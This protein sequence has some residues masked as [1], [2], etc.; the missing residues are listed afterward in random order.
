[1]L[2][3]QKVTSGPSHRRVSTLRARMTEEM[4]V[5]GFTVAHRACVFQ[6]MIFR[7]YKRVLRLPCKRRALSNWKGDGHYIRSAGALSL[8]G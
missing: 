8:F 7:S 3:S 5:R 1:V 4:T 6:T 2:V